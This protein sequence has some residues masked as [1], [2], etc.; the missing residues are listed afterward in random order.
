MKTTDPP[1]VPRLALLIIAIVPVMA[2]T[3]GLV[4]GMLQKAND[5]SSAAYNE[6]GGTAQESLGAIRTLAS[7]TGEL[8]QLLC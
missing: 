1:P 2:G 5:E 8:G 7:L 4:A 6:A 3:L